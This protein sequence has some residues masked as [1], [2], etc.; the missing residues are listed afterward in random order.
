M[1]REV[2]YWVFNMSIAAAITGVPVLLLRTAKRLPGRFRVFLWA[3]PFLRMVLPLGVNS[4]YS[5][6][7]LLSKIT[8]RAVVVYQPAE[9]LSFSVMN[10]AMAANT[11][12]PVTYKAA[13]LENIFH[14]AS[15][16]WCAV[17]LGILLLLA[18][19][20]RTTVL[21]LKDATLLRDN[22]Y[23]SEKIDSPGVYGILKPRILLP[24][25]YKDRD[26]HLVL[27]HEQAHIRSLDN[28]WRVIGLVTAALH[29]FNP[30]GWLFLKSFLAD[31][32]LA[33]D[34]RV[35]TGLGAHRAKEYA[36][37]LLETKCGATVF[38]SPFGGAKLRTRIENIL[39]FRRLTWLSLVIFA[40]LLAV[41]SYVLLTNPG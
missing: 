16:I 20:Y 4:P 9:D 5:L 25:S 26:L 34:E 21:E 27:L 23:L 24:A 2:F 8:A 11:Y 35:L 38:V 39:S 17:A 1:L 12:F 37:T 18:G 14:V 15:V 19:I 31:L 28:L 32:E 36:L 3:I 40:S 33:C 13:L 7:S 22:I 10:F 30:L 29:W 41:I 6:M